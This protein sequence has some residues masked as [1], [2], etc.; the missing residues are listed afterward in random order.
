MAPFLPESSSAS[1]S[2]YSEQTAE[3]IDQEVRKLLADAQ[4]RVRDTLETRQAELVALAKALLSQEVVDRAA[5]LGILSAH[6]SQDPTRLDPERK[7][8]VP[9]DTSAD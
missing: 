1:R 7:A 6:G 4:E 9:A 3:V 2:D 5:L 8:D